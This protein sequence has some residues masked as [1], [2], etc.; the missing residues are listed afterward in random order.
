MK[1]FTTFMLA[2]LLVFTAGC[3][4]DG[5]TTDSN[6]NVVNGEEITSSYSPKES[7]DDISYEEGIYDNKDWD[8]IGGSFDEIRIQDKDTAIKV[9]SSILDGMQTRGGFQDVVLYDVFFDTEDKLWIVGFCIRDTENRM[10]PGGDLTIVLRAD[11]A[12]VITTIWG[13]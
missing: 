5:H 6:T 11:N 1:K 4:I 13:E 2:V 3:N 9:A 10:I 12:Q 7:H 8:N